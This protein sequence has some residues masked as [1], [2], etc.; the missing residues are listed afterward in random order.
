M[1]KRDLIR[2]LVFVQIVLGIVMIY[3]AKSY[4]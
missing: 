3:L 4:G 1:G 2:I